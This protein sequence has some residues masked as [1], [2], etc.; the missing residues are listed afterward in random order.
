MES[1]WSISNTVHTSG[2]IF[3][4][5]LSGLPGARVF[6]WLR[7]SDL[8]CQPSELPQQYQDEDGEASVDSTRSF[9]DRLQRVAFACSAFIG[10]TAAFARY[11]LTLNTGKSLDRALQ[12]GIWSCLMLQS[13]ALFTEPTAP[14]RFSIALQGSANCLN[15]LCAL[16]MDI[17]A[18]TIDWNSFDWR[19]R[20][21]IFVEFAAVG[22]ACLHGVLL[23]RRPDVFWKGS[24][25]D[26]QFTSSWLCRLSFSWPWSALRAAPGKTTFGIDGLPELDRKTRSRYL[27][28]RF[29][30]DS[31]RTGAISPLW[32]TLAFSY[33]RELLR[34][35][36][37]TI[38]GSTISF[39]PQIMLL[40]VLRAMENEMGDDNRL[41][42]LAPWV[43]TLG[44]SIVISASV[45]QWNIWFS[46]MDLGLKM[47]KQLTMVLF[48][49]L[50]RAR[51]SSLNSP[52]RPEQDDKSSNPNASG[53]NIINLIAVDT[54][55]VGNCV[56][57]MYRGYEAFIKLVIAGILIGRLMGWQSLVAG[58][59]FVLLLF[60]INVYIAKQHSHN[61]SI[62][63]AY[64]DSRMAVVTEA[65]Q[66]VRQIKFSGWENSWERGILQ[67]R[68]RELNAQWT[69]SQWTIAAQTI[70]TIGPILLSVV[71]IAIHVY[72]SGDL[73]PSIAFT[74][75]SVLGSVETSLGVI[76]EIQ[77][78]W[79]GA[80]IS[81]KRL[82]SYLQT[83][84][85][86]FLSTVDDQIIL[87]R[88]TIRWP[89]SG[90][91]SFSLSDLTLR[92]PSHA[93]SVIEGPTRSGKSLLL[94]AILGE[95]DLVRGAV[96]KPSESA[97]AYVAQT[98]WIENASI[99][100]NILF[101]CP[102]N[103]E[104][105]RQV[106]HACAL[107]KDLAAFTEGDRT[108]IGPKGVNLS[109][110]QRSRIALARALYSQASILV[111]DDIFSAVDAHTA[112]HLC[113]HVLGG[114]LVKSRTLILVSH[115]LSL[116]A[117]HA[118]Y[119]VSLTRH[120][121]YKAG[122]ATGLARPDFV[123]ALYAEKG[124]EEEIEE[125]CISEEGFETE[126]TSLCRLSSLGSFDG[127]ERAS[128]ESSS[129]PRRYI[130]DEEQRTV[131]LLH[132]ILLQYLRQI[133]NVWYGVFVV[134]V[135]MGY[136]GSVVGQS[137][138]VARWAHQN[139]GSSPRT[140]TS[141]IDNSLT[142]HL[143]IYIGFSGLACVAGT[144]RNFLTLSSAICAARRLFVMLQH[145][146]L[147]APLD[148]L[149]R[150]PPGRILNRFSSDTDVLD[151]Q[152]GQVLGGALISALE[153]LAIFVVGT[154]A[155]W[156]ILPISMVMFLFCVH[157]AYRFYEAARNLKQL[158]SISRSPV[159]E[160]FSSTIE[161]LPTI[162]ALGLQESYRHK[163]ATQVDDNTRAVWNL[164]LV[165][166]WFGYRMVLIGA[167]FVTVATFAIISVPGTTAAMTGFALSFLLRYTSV[168][169]AF[170]R[171]YI[172]LELALTSVDRVLE[173]AQIPSEKYDGV[174]VPAAWPDQGLLNVSHL[175]VRYS[176][177]LQ[178]ALDRVS[179]QLLPNQRIGVLGRTGAGK[180]SL[181][182]ALFRFLEAEQGSI[183]L[184]GIDISG[185]PLQQLRQRMA[186][187]PQDPHLFSG[188]VR[189]NL[190]PFDAYDDL[191]LL[192]ALECVHWTHIETKTDN[193]SILSSSASQ[194]S[195]SQTTVVGL[196]TD[197]QKQWVSPLDEEIIDSGRNLSQGQRQQLCLARAIASRPKILIMD[198]ATSSIDQR[199]DA[200]IQKSIRE[201]FGRG[202]TSLLVIAHRVS[203]VLD[204]D[205]ILVLD[206]GRV[207]EFG[208]P[209]D[210]IQRVGG[211]FR[212]LVEDSGHT[213]VAELLDV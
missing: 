210:L 135:Y 133:G 103:L 163:L 112:Q 85:S 1:V 46:S 87:E 170:I 99:T 89:G 194:P 156:W 180:T 136:V 52:N 213:G 26:R 31:A 132:W 212:T 3:A 128:C 17:Y 142:W 181:T 108:E 98:P 75:L 7:R 77:S 27:L 88:A 68:E 62:L 190:D 9:A 140:T 50:L 13:L 201:S 137:W 154:S 16:A 197:L 64:K 120:G 149:D 47:Q 171:G 22:I 15:V 60:A 56:R 38:I 25:V 184:D 146:V 11:I 122:P 191:D 192:H 174:A 200:L 182:M 24:L 155:S 6:S 172:N 14:A 187:I 157:S 43:C 41:A 69:V 109:G 164:W 179:F 18:N 168:V 92:F 54:Q 5:A 206:K 97:I 101:G 131:G 61:Q 93:L 91:N 82:Q 35:L 165:N 28:Q 72:I 119:I 141:V 21:L 39:A 33:R 166:C 147:Y 195:S 90:P 20:L 129:I 79:L 78:S 173:Y 59:A 193:E 145:S 106:V 63:M 169:S 102:M 66:G 105:Y 205:R 58:T 162:R 175:V 57:G 44:L 67:Q 51:G 37:L 188:T 36:A 138:W 134:L 123:D 208:S 65:L 10:S 151:S 100:D 144:L 19:D 30:Y 185:V 148:F 125:A 160:R 211:H 196:D 76:P 40:G 176:P 209:R 107:N 55:Q 152:I 74:S 48:D 34:Q 159:L 23:P 199:T 203:T 167:A 158:D 121:K 127:F 139:T 117:P 4:I 70:Y 84:E 183:M 80:S 116:C 202:F 71:T 53:H 113:K 126:S 86:R 161:G 95:C 2:L 177:Y 143:G 96:K 49:K 8:Q 104:R 118:D 198:E 124:I 110:G 186:I 81:I 42:T 73:K 178:P 32:K 204:F 94:A 83:P 45:Q 114:P 111:M 115:H 29:Q 207:V 12:F 130:E 153:L 189:S 150:N